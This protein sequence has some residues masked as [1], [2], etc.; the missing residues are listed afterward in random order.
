MSE[1]KPLRYPGAYAGVQSA[2]PAVI[3]AQS[4]AAMSYAELDAY[5]NRL[6]RFYRSLGR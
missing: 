6:A 2:K 4:G 1:T 3:M 5:A